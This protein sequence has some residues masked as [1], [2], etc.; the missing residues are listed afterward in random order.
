MLQTSVQGGSEWNIPPDNM[1]YLCNQW[2]DF[3]NSWSCLILTLAI[4]YK[5]SGP[6]KKIPLWKIVIFIVIA[7][8]GSVVV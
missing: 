8:H 6:T 5:Y 4:R 1:Q 2:S 7:L 3:K